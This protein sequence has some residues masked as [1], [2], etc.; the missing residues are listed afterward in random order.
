MGMFRL[1][2]QRTVRNWK[3]TL[4]I[5]FG[6]FLASTLFASINIEATIIQESLITASVADIPADI[7]WQPRNPSG[8]HLILNTTTL[9]QRCTT[10]EAIPHVA[11]ADP[12][13]VN[14]QEPGPLP[15]DIIY[16]TA[17]LSNASIYDQITV[18]E[19]K[20]SLGV[21]ETYVATSSSRFNDFP[22]GSS[23][24]I[25]FLNDS[26]LQNSIEATLRVVGFVDITEHAEWL[27]SGLEEY[28]NP[29]EGGF[30]SY[31]I[32]DLEHT[33][34]PLLDAYWR[35]DPLSPNVRIQIAVNLDRTALIQPY[36]VPGTV[37]RI[38]Q[39]VNEIR[40]RI[41][42]TNAAISNLLGSQLLTVQG[43]LTTQHLNLTLLVLPIV[44]VT[45]YLGIT[46]GDVTFSLRRREIG[47][48][49][50]R[51]G[52]HRQ[53]IILYFIEALIIGISA[54]LF[55]IALA[56]FVVPLFIGIESLISLELV[57][58]GVDTVG[59]VLIFASVLAILSIFLPARKALK[60]PM[61]EALSEYSVTSES[62]QYRKKTAWLCLILGAYKIVAWIFGLNVYLAIM[63]FRSESILA[64]F[65]LEGWLYFEAILA[66]LAPLLFTYGFSMVIMKG[67]PGLSQR[68]MNLPRRLFGDLG[69]ISTHNLRHRPASTAATLFIFAILLGFSIQSIGYSVSS[70]DWIVR[71]VYTDVGA[72][73]QVKVQHPDNVSTLLTTIRGV[74]GVQAAAAQDILSMDFA[75]QNQFSTSNELRAIN[76]GD[77]LEVAYFEEGWFQPG[78]AEAIIRSLNTEENVL[79]LEHILATYMNLHVGSSIN[80]RMWP[81]QT[82]QPFLVAGFFGP[83]P[84]DYSHGRYLDLRAEITWSYTS[85][86]S[87]ATLGSTSGYESYILVRLASI[88]ENDGVMSVLNSLD[89]VVECRSAVQILEEY[90]SR[91]DISSQ[92]RTVQLVVFFLFLLIIAGTMITQYLS[93]RERRRTIALMCQR[94]SSYR[95]TVTILAGEALI[96][97][98]F[99]ALIGLFVGF[100]AYYGLIS[101]LNFTWIQPFPVS[102]SLP[103]PVLVS[104]QFL[105]LPFISLFAGLLGALIALLVVL[106][107]VLIPIEAHK[108]QSDISILR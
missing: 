17:I 89:G 88:T 11:N 95:Q 35:I 63:A 53:L 24:T 18:V 27:L 12:F 91:L 40:N 81:N 90:S 54:G 47:L 80:L 9:L 103:E 99:A 100:M 50:A 92:Q 49:L 56:I 96:I 42:L 97:S 48:L 4:T 51:T 70:E 74:D 86:A 76:P 23:F 29:G 82:L 84:I 43:A 21:N 3:L 65:L 37:V 32:V 67:S 83:E 59:L 44:F 73:I 8:H 98:V 58:L 41:P 72:D 108:A 6:I 78:S 14:R 38:T 20:T 71:S 36:N 106:P 77:W 25:Q 28:I 75:L 30:P 101:Y 57:F 52:T 13:V 64:Y 102:M 61:L 94:G 46:L 105:P 15:G 7:T 87:I 1:S 26:A 62:I 34:A 45:F 104:H 85:I 68:I 39:I 93:L 79:I 107:L 22:L 19:G 66:L 2:L 33:F 5:F 10:I 16:T 60:I 55:G 69:A 31:F